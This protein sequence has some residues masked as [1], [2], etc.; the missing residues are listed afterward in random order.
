MNLATPLVDGLVA[1]RRC[2]GGLVRQTAL[3]IGHRRRLE[4]DSAHPP[5]VRRKLKIQEI[6][7]KYRSQMKESDFYAHLF[8]SNNV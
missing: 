1:S 2:V 7:H 5:L 4:L 6:V 8:Q 3:N